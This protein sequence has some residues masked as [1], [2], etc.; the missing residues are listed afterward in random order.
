M[1]IKIRNGDMI[2]TRS[3]GLLAVTDYVDSPMDNLVIATPDF[4]QE[5]Y[6]SDGKLIVVDPSLEVLTVNGEK[7]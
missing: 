4:D 2:E 1:T 3:H 6:N 5:D 7:Y